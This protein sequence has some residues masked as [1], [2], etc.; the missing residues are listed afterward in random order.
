VRLISIIALVALALGARPS[1]ATPIAP[2]EV[3]DYGLMRPASGWLLARDRL[4]LTQDEGE[5]WQDV[6]PALQ[7][8]TS[9]AADFL[10]DGQ[11]WLLAGQP[12]REERSILALAHT[13]DFG[14]SWE[15]VPLPLFAS[16]DPDPTIAAV[17]LA[18]DGPQEG[19][20]RVRHVSSSNFERWS[21]WHTVDG[22]TSWTRVA[23][24]DV[25]AAPDGTSEG[26]DAKFL[27]AGK[28]GWRIDRSGRCAGSGSNRTC[29]QETALRATHDGGQTWHALALPP[30]IARTQTWSVPDTSANAAAVAVASRTMIAAGQ[31]FDKCE[32]PTLDQLQEWRR[33]SPYSV[34][35]LY[36]GGA[37]RACANQALSADYLR[38]AFSMGWTFIPTW[39]GPQAPCTS[40][41]SRISSD[42]ATAQSQGWAEA[43]AAANALAWLGLAEPAGA[44]SI[45]YYDMEYYNT[46]DGA[47][48]AA[49]QSFVTGWTQA[50]RAR[51]NLAGVYGAGSSLLL[52]ANLP[53]P[54]DAIW[55]AHWLY[56]SYN[57][58]ATV[59]D[60]YRLDNKLWSNHQRLR[61]YTGGHP[62]TW[63]SVALTIDPNVLDGP[64]ALM[65]QAPDTPTPT[66]T[67]TPT[68]TRAPWTPT[69]WS[70]LP[71]L[72]QR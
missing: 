69:A 59:W 43:S 1:P 35:N 34:V 38:S 49:V 52:L 60:V 22:G 14:A 20:L 3:V 29:E 39:V 64:V 15:W 26:L 5:T 50:L 40:F 13:T 45:V 56:S 11:G 4:Y 51:G 21:E 44:G 25:T 66:A 9:L 23:E 67:P 70:Y 47:C 62:E 71:L 7:G 16:D 24:R 58:D 46:T 6:T 65:S 36:I 61:Q 8:N 42:I 12:E 10:G 27:P 53:Q 68:P 2:V 41:R 55:A 37:A 18:F 28:D 17:Q 19:K 63:G 57:P 54:P 30:G 48:N 31:G 33:A 32:I 72:V